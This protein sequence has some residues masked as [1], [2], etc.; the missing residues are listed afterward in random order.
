[1]NI[2][3]ARRRPLAATGW[4]TLDFLPGIVDAICAPR[5]TFAGYFLLEM[6]NLL[7]AAFQRRFKLC[8]ILEREIERFDAI[9]VDPRDF[10]VFDAFERLRAPGASS[11]IPRRRPASRRQ[12]FP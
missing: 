8:D 12:Q 9:I 10:R 3:Q 11:P 7:V 6:E 5:I 4:R 2:R 1:M